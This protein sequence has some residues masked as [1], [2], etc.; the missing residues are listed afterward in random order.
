MRL[1]PAIFIFALLLAGPA[2]A[3]T[4][5]PATQPSP[6]T[7]LESLR[8]ENAKLKEQVVALKQQLAS[9]QTA[10]ASTQAGVK[11]KVKT[12]Q[13]MMEI[14]AKVPA[15]LR[16]K[17]EPDW[18]KY[19]AA[20]YYKWVEEQMVG[21]EFDRKMNFYDCTI[22]RSPTSRDVSEWSIGPILFNDQH[23]TYFGTDNTWKID[24]L[25]I[26]VDETGSRMWNKT[27]KG[28]LIQVKGIIRAVTISRQGIYYDNNKLPKL[29]YTIALR[30][31]VITHPENRPYK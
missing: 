22:T 1:A 21:M 2:I 6:P 23:F 3:Q 7:E 19:T 17:G 26:F 9:V 15:E 31:V 4:T 20:K 27:K 29:T 13:T 11:E 30:D 18:Y 25:R 16:P 10:T 24:Y 12:F 14:L 28:T 5:L 8:L